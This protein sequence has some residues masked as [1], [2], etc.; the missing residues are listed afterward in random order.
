VRVRV[1]LPLVLGS[2]ALVVAAMVTVVAGEAS[3][4]APV[5]LGPTVM[6]LLNNSLKL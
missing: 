4:F 5:K 6:L 2:L 3:K 1:K